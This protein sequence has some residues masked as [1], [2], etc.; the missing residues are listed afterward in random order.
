VFGVE[1]YELEYNHITRRFR[2]TQKDEVY[3]VKE[4]GEIRLTRT[5][6]ILK[7][8]LIGNKEDNDEGFIILE[9]CFCDIFMQTMRPFQN[10]FRWDTAE[11]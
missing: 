9:Y 3:K 2:L 11:N 5:H 8:V 6:K 10:H 4:A 7:P 1:L